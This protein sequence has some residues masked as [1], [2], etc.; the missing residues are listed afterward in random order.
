M[1]PFLITAG[2]GSSVAE[3][4][5]VLSILIC[6]PAVFG[7]STLPTLSMEKYLTV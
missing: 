7:D 3:L 5:M 4:G 6:V 2:S 1:W